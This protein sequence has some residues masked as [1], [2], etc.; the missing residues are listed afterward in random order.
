MSLD[1]VLYHFSTKINKN[2]MSSL[3]FWKLQNG[4]IDESCLNCLSSIRVN[5][6]Q[7]KEMQLS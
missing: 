7:N 1:E 2:K 4:F 6:L 5:L 3:A